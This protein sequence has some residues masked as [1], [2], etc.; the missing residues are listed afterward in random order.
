MSATRRLAA[1]MFTDMVGSTT[2]AQANEAA[3]LELLHEQQ[4][5]VRPIF[6]HHQGKEIKSMGDGFLV[7]FD[8]ALRGAECAVEIQ[9][10]LWERN[11]RPGVSPILLRVGF[12]LGDVEEL[13]GDI[14]G[15]AVNI[16]SRIEPLADSSGICI[17]G[18][19]FDQVRNKIPYPCTQLEHAFLKNVD[20]PIPVY[21]VDLPWVVPPAARVTPWTDRESELRTLDAIVADAAAGRGQ[22]VAFSGEPGIGK[23]RLADEAI[24]KAEAKGFRT[25]RGRGHQDE[26][27]V[28]Y[29]LWV[30]AVRGF[31]REV[32]ATLLYKVSTGSGAALVK[33]APEV[34]ER[35]GPIP[36]AEDD[37][38]EV[39]RLRFFEGIAQFFVNLSHETPV[40]ILLDD[41][42]WADPGSLRLLT[43]LAEP[44]RGRPMLLF[45]T[46][47]D[48]VED[49]TPLLRTVIQDLTHAH[50]LVRVSV[51]RMEGG[52][53]RQLVG[54]ILG[55]R[56]PP[57]E[58]VGLVG[59]KTGGNPLFVEELLRSMTEEDQLVRRGGNW[60]SSGIGNVG[61]PSTMRDVIL[62][63]LARAGEQSQSLLSVGSVLGQEFDFELLQQISGVEAEPLLTQ[64]EAL[65]RARLLREREVSPGR[66]VYLFADDQTREVLYQELSLVR[67]QRYHLKA[68]Q[69]I[70]GRLAHQPDVSAG[71]LALHYQRGNDP[72]KALEWTLVAAKNSVKLYA[73]EQ[74][75]SYFRSALETLKVA[76]DERVQAEVLEQLSNELEILGQYEEST[77][78]RT[79]ASGLYEKLG[80]HRRAGAMLRLAATHARWTLL[81]EFDVDEAQLEHARALLES[82]EP[83]PE[84]VQLYLNYSSFLEAAGR[85]DEVRPI[86]T[87]AVEV[88]EALGDATLRAA[89]RLELLATLPVSSRSEALR[90][91]DQVVELARSLGPEIAQRADVAQI[92]FILGDRGDLREG[93]EAVQRAAE[94]ARTINAPDFAEGVVGSLGAFTTMLMGDL[95]ESLRRAQRHTKYFEAR[96]QPQTAHNLLHYA[97]PAIIRGEFADGERYL[98]AAK[99]I[100]ASEKAVLQ[101]GWYLMFRGLLELRRGNAVE[102]EALVLKAL[103]LDHVQGIRAL[104]VFRTIWYLSTLI[105]CAVQQHA[106]DRADNYL[107]ELEGL[108]AQV[109]NDPARAFLTRGH[110]VRA[111]EAGDFARAFDLLR[112]SHELWRKTQ[113]RHQ[114]GQTCLELAEAEIGLGHAERVGPMLDEAIEVLSSMPAQPELA[115]AL[116]LQK[117][118]RAKSVAP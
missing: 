108:V 111:L 64:I 99:A 3:A 9:R 104:L 32:P 87:R 20:T 17:S 103:E 92:I 86:L 41:L 80:D 33:L 67:R 112:E 77:R 11:A 4:G 106:P 14:F 31:L 113:W 114:L 74:A 29:S 13:D 89:V 90:E 78:R 82:V 105:D 117:D 60:D 83:C 109:N 61:V 10:Q 97:Y 58:L 42:Q 63:R 71:E 84:L 34:A 15:D 55:T 116:A 16:A 12:H 26:Q 46:F 37:S 100:L 50:A 21:S 73:R 44:V 115:R 85:Y 51:K 95:D 79:E 81:G 65:L 107:A 52:P 36:P 2:A 118:W 49:E 94:R 27:P 23:T 75:I 5:L 57:P 18:P 59:Q 72:R 66:S 48:T 70:E 53:A 88:A 39:A 7:E 91:I 22:V 96:G 8:S 68:A 102:G 56:D 19:V 40:V 47:R 30:Q 35:L 93:E 28:P 76:P 25:L 98:D 101:D 6:A 54:A 45:L 38:S 62:K 43:Y 1:I 69:L 110:G 24:R